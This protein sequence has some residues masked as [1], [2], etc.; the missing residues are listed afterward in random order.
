MEKQK[1][2]LYTR[3]LMR[4]Y[5]LA[6]LHLMISALGL[7]LNHYRLNSDYLFF[8]IIGL[9]LM[10]LVCFKPWRIASYLREGYGH[11]QGLEAVA[12]ERGIK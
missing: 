5:S 4:M 8:S 9:N 6:T 3:Q 11:Q 2:T 1:I 12:Q 10:A 7:A